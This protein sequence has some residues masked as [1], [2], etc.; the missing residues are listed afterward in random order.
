MGRV[1][2]P[3]CF[4]PHLTVNG[5]RRQQVQTYR[6]NIVRQLC[7]SV[8]LS[9]HVQGHP[10][11]H[12]T[13]TVRQLYLSVYLYLHAQGRPS[14]H[15]TKTVRQLSLCVYLYLHVQWHPNLHKTNTVRQ[16]SLCVSVST[17]ARAPPA[18]IFV[19]SGLLRRGGRGSQTEKEYQV[20]F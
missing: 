17:C 11:L 5:K 20:I 19:S 18:C 7:L 8:Y 10:S 12:E 1:D 15:R 16:L 13:N 3:S 6:L 9:L 4:R 14:L 2:S